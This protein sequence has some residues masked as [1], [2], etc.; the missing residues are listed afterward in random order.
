[1]VELG[2]KPLIGPPHRSGGSELIVETRRIV[3]CIIKILNV[4]EDDPD[5]LAV[6]RPYP[7]SKLCFRALAVLMTYPLIPG[8]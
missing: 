6:N 7:G 5:S 3:I 2:M 1:M 4:P 8:K